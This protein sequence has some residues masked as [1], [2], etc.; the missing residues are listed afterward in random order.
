MGIGI[1]IPANVFKKGQQAYKENPQGEFNDVTLT[2][3]RYAAI[4]TTARAIETSK[5]PQVVLDCKVA[6]ESEHAGGRVSIWFS[7]A[8]DRIVDLFKCLAILG[9]EVE[10]L[11]EKLLSDIFDDIKE[12]KHC[13][14]LTCKQNGEYVNVYLDKKLDD[15]EASA[16]GGETAADPD[17]SGG[18][19]GAEDGAHAKADDLEEKTRDELKAIIEEEEVELAVKKSTTEEQM[20]EAIRAK[21][22]EGGAKKEEQAKE[23]PA[24]DGLDDMD[25]AALKEIVEAEEVD[26]AI[27]KS[28]S[29]DDIRKAVRAHRESKSAGEPE[30]PAEPEGDPSGAEQSVELEVGMAVKA[31]VKGKMVEAKVVSID[32]KKG[33]VKV[34]T[35]DG[36]VHKVTGDELELMA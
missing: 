28:T 35:K 30:A 13:V 1:K 27:K 4:L 29:E 23:E 11:D 25:R 31:K 3:G 7:L 18:K 2:P 33:E 5:G 22:S 15:L 9:Y 12:S 10:E 21:R 17:V 8:E 19:A 16:E 26:I 36:G 24:S 20:V 14:R 6:G 34:K 32:E